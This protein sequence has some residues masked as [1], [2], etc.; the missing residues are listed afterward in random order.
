MPASPRQHALSTRQRY[1]GRPCKR[2]GNTERYPT[3]GCISCMKSRPTKTLRRQGI[4][5]EALAAG[6][7]TYEGLACAR[8][9]GTTRWSIDS[10]CVPCNRARLRNRRAIDPDKWR[11]RDQIYRDANRDKLRAAA[12]RYY[13]NNCE[14]KKEYSRE[15]YAEN[16]NP[17]TNR[18]RVKTWRKNNPE[19]YAITH[20]T[21]AARRR[22]RGKVA[23]P[24]WLKVSG[25]LAA[26]RKLYSD[27]RKAGLHVDHNIPISGC[28]SCGA[29]GLHVL[30]NLQTITAELNIMK[31]AR[32]M[33]C[34]TNGHVIG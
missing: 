17:D 7:K 22:S 20:N 24:K 30:S 29:L 32:C 14:A 13:W 4:R 1:H 11:A 12:M 18:L 27:A 34:F 9:G 23:S 25:Q 28:R 26:I 19:K 3:G 33:E 21:N 8:C 16:P 10:R 5:Q 15:Y 6:H 31:G 2:C